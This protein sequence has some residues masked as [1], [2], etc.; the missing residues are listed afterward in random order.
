MERLYTLIE[1]ENLTGH[2]R[3]TLRRQ[4]DAGTLAGHKVLKGQRTIWKLDQTAVDRLLGKK[5]HQS[6]DELLAQWQTEQASGYHTGKPIGHRGVETNLYGMGKYWQYLEMEPSIEAIS[7][8]NFRRAV[9][10]VPVDHKAKNCHFTQ[11]DQMFKGICSFYKLLIRLGIKTEEDL[12]ALKQWKP[13]RIYPPQKTVLTEEQ[14]NQLLEKN[15]TWMTS[16]TVFD[17]ELTRVLI[18]FMTQTGLR[19]AEA[20]DLLLEDVDLNAGKLVV[21]DGKGHKTRTVGITPLLDESLRLWL[22]QYRPQCKT[23]H[24]FV[25][26]NGQP[27]TTNVLYR[28]I[29]RLAEAAGIDINVH[30]LRRTFA[31]TFANHGAPIVYVQNQLGHS[32]IKTTQGYLMTDTQQAVD[33]LRNFGAKPPVQLQ[34]T[35]P[36]QPAQSAINPMLYFQML[37]DGF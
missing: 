17:R 6:Y 9:T 11:R 4:L 8:E 1:A 31:T 34:P 28:R 7:A 20:M 2:R 16:R 13:K 29:K 32:S 3:C 27:I 24:F 18:I 25:Q 10:N 19:K 21:Q 33:W 23:S 26:E 35:Q 12:Q 37:N 5:Q 36:I 15:E 14:V 30:G 22:E